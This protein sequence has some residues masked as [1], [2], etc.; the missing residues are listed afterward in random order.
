MPQNSF[1]GTWKLNAS[2]SSLSFNRPHSVIVDIVVDGNVAALKESSIEAQ[3][4]AEVVSIRAR[5]DKQI[6]PVTGSRLGEGF[7]IE[8]LGARTWRARGTTG[9]K[10]MFVGTV[11][12]TVDGTR[13]REEVVTPLP[14]G[15][16]APATLI[17]EHKELRQT[18]R[19]KTLREWTY[20]ARR[21][22]INH[23][24]HDSILPESLVGHA[25]SILV[26]CGFSSFWGGHLPV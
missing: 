2:A 1:T 3:G 15:S 18:W 17:Y 4:S 9:G 12:L 24:S 5:F 25:E 16:C 8:H 11:T 13:I 14:D 26:R 7:A 21:G 23:P 19:Y 6:Y 10:L 20:V 22:A